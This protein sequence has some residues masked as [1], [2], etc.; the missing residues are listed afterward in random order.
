MIY[1]IHAHV[2]VDEPAGEGNYLAAPERQGRTMR[3][4]RRRLASGIQSHG[5]PAEYL[6][7]NLEESSI[8]R[9]V[10]LAFDGV[11]NEDG[12]FNRERTVLV[13]SNDYAAGLASRSRKALFGASIHPYRK[14][15]VCELER[16]AQKGACL[17]KWLP[18]AQ[19]IDP[20][21]IRCR[22]F[23]EALAGLRMPLL[24]HTGVEH[25]IPTFP[26]ELND[27]SRLRLALQC[28]VTVI[29]AHC[30]SRLFLHE[31]TYFRN[32]VEMVRESGSLYGDVSTFGLPLHGRLLEEILADRHL[33]SRVVY[34]SD[35]PA[36]VMPL[37]YAPAIGLNRA[38][39]IRRAG[40]LFDKPYMMMKALG[41]PDDV[42]GRAGELLRLPARAG[43][44]T[45]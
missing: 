26:H 25:M 43:E 42:F 28:G 20:G 5:S 12:S 11:W 9:A 36:Y 35:F 23:Y 4:V 22:G 40:N 27:P 32:W 21:D 3:F 34:G 33:V 29:A 24:T 14:D 44:A 30:G 2:I 16:V 10:L 15:S 1:D 13:V 41:V 6:L 38:Q 39:A 45:L 18:S 17:V 31:K 37:W 7:K 8:D 19:G